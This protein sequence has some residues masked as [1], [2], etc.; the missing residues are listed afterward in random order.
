MFQRLIFKFL[1]SLL[2]K[3]LKIKIYTTIILPVVFYGCGTWLLTLREEHRDIDNLLN[4]IGF[5]CGR[6][7][8]VQHTQT[9]GGS[10]YITSRT[11]YNTRTMHSTI[12]RKTV[13]QSST[14]SQTN[15]QH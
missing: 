14:M 15:K 13:T 6:S 9:K 2:S 12:H 4:A 10:T 11:Q 3:N 1:A 5:T 8:Y 7:V